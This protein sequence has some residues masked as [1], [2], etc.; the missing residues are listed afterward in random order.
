MHYL[1]FQF[2]EIY[3]W[4]ENIGYGADGTHTIRDDI[5]FPIR[6]TYIDQE[7]APDIIHAKNGIIERIKKELLSKKEFEGYEF[8]FFA[9]Y[10]PAAIRA[11]FQCPN[12]FDYEMLVIMTNRNKYVAPRRPLDR[13]I[14][15]GLIETER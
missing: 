8:S 2:P 12:M 6:P 7:F 9:P 11:D 1:V 10:E 15:Y 14:Y 13:Y 5:E 3:Y 4:S